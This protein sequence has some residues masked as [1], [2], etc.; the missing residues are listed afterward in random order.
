MPTPRARPQAQCPRGPVSRFYSVGKIAFEVC[1]NGSVTERDFA[2]PTK[3]RFGGH[4]MT[5]QP[6]ISRRH[7]LA[8]SA[9][10]GGAAASGL[11]A[12]LAQQ[13]RPFPAEVVLTPRIDKF[14][15]ALDNIISTSQTIPA[16]PD[17]FAR[18]LPPAPPPPC[19][20]QA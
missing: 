15:P 12:A 17:A 3:P 1:P 16:I 4:I 14:D 10:A 7:M 13:R 2:H 8:L 9:A 18:P 5:T 11:G 6:H 19:V 20:K